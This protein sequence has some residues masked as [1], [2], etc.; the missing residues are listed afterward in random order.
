MLLLSDEDVASSDGISDEVMLSSPS[1]LLGIVPTMQSSSICFLIAND[2]DGGSKG[3]GI[4][5][6]YVEVKLYIDKCNMIVD[7]WFDIVCQF[8]NIRDTT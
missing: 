2:G 5:D 1:P 8:Q 4:A 6:R 3:E 7:V